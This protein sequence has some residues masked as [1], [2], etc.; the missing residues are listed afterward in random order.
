MLGHSGTDGDEDRVKAAGMFFG[1]Q[2]LHLVVGDDLDAHGL[3]AFDLTHQVPTRQAVGRDSEM[4][5][6]TG[7]RAR[8]ANLNAMPETGEMIGG[9][10]SARPGTD[11]QNALAGRRRFEPERP[12]LP[13]S[14]IAQKALNSVNSH[15]RI[16]LAAIAGRFAG[17]IADASV[18][19]RH[20]VIAYQSLP[21]LTVLARLCQIEPGLDVLPGWAGLVA[22]WK[23]IDKDRTLHSHRP[24]SLLAGQVDNWRHVPVHNKPPWFFC[25]SMSVR[26]QLE[27]N[28]SEP[29]DNADSR[30]QGQTI[31][32]HT[33]STVCSADGNNTWSL[34]FCDH[35]AEFGFRAPLSI[36]QM[37]IPL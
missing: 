37:A 32:R 30:P 12:I 2:I 29:V 11:D 28:L 6:A 23:Q 1:E 34:L 25:L 10:Q 18:Y 16:Q 24:G 7:H 4:H 15:R 13:A 21:C 27:R 5:H 8:I 9:R 36:I 19:R 3:D 14:E 17:V 22:W 35:Q 31:S 20:R 26:A 33:E